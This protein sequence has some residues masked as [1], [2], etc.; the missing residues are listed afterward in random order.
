ML[1]SLRLKQVE[2][3][4]ET[5]SEDPREASNLPIFWPQ[6]FLSQSIPNATIMT[7][8][9]DADVIGDFFAR[10]GR[11]KN[12]ISQHGQD[13]MVKLGFHISGEV[14]Q[15]KR[16]TYE[17]NP[18]CL[19]YTRTRSSSLLTAWAGSLSKM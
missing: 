15:S 1:Y 5:K 12:T 3:K 11:S 13:L 10:D 17:N 19:T 18:E 4:I 16:Y 9:Y 8:G 6:D 7:Y 2:S 14:L